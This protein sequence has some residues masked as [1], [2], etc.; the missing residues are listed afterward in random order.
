M[1]FYK[2]DAISFIESGEDTTV[3]KIIDN[4]IAD[5]NDHPDLPDTIFE[6]GHKYYTKAR[7]NVRDGF[8]EQ[9]TE[10]YQKAI[11]QWE[12]IINIWPRC[13]YAPRAYYGSAVVYSQELG[14]YLKGISYYQRI[15]DNWSD[16]QY[17][18]HAQ[19][20]VGKNYEIL[21]DS[22]SVTESEANP[23]MEQAYKSVIEKYPDSK[24]APQAA[25]K[26]GRLYLFRKEW[27]EAATHLEFFRQKSSQQ[28]DQVLL[29]LG[30]AYEKIGNLDEALQFYTE[31][32]ETADPADPRL[33]SLI[34]KLE[35]LQGENK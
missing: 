16:Y 22:G 32:I 26:M 1:G 5:F 12:R 18:S 33:Q 10:Y 31:F 21:R 17:A 6:L 8:E 25:L 27:S 14:E 35:R 13:S 7:L 2:M 24:Y 15:V 28:R 4:L 3:N 30:F 20:L 29:D 19:F 9:A 11:T 23:K 34:A